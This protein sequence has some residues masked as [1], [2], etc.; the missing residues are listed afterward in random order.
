MA[1]IGTFKKT[2]NNEFVGDI[3]TLGVQAKGVRVVPDSNRANDVLR[4]QLSRSLGQSH[5]HDE[6]IGQ[7]ELA[8]NL[9]A[10]L[11]EAAIAGPG[12]TELALDDPEDV[13]DLGAERRRQP[14][15]PALFIGQRLT[16]PALER[17]SPDDI[18]FVAIGFERTLVAGI[19]TVAK[20][21]LLLAVEQCVG[22]H[23]V[24]HIGAPGGSTHGSSTA[25]HLPACRSAGRTKPC[26]SLR[27]ARPA[28]ASPPRFVP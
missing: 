1:T 16:L 5:A 26:I 24:M 2:A 20:S 9:L 23:A 10:V 4:A 15:D 19:G 27:S 28:R 21:N 22:H 11:V 18:A 14:V 17:R 12:V 25:S 6:D 3:V 8:E 7:G 13:L